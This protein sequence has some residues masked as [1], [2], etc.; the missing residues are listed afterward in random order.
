MPKKLVWEAAAEARLVTP[1]LK[2]KS[3][4]ETAPLASNPN[5]STEK[6]P[7][8][9]CQLWLPQPERV[10]RGSSSQKTSFKFKML[11]TRIMRINLRLSTRRL[12]T[13]L[14]ESNKSINK[15]LPSNRRDSTPKKRRRF[16]KQATTTTLKC[17]TT[18]L[19]LAGLT[20]LMSSNN[21]NQASTL[22]TWVS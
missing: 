22:K 1:S 16:Q 21:N 19:T 5:Q 12:M 9:K 17:S 2:S 4:Q 6:Q 14:G 11:S 13:N 7:Q 15:F 3:H 8:S 18:K 20:A 10:W